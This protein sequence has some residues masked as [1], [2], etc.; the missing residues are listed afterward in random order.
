MFIQA[1]L[2]AIGAGRGSRRACVLTVV[3]GTLVLTVHIAVLMMAASGSAALA[4]EAGAGIAE[5]V[6]PFFGA[7]LLFA[8]LACAPS[9]LRRADAL[10]C[11]VLSGDLRP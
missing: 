3:A 5:A 8:M 10:A 1:M 11:R 9:L 2:E 6:G 7:A 4:A